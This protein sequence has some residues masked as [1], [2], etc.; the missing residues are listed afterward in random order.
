M[1]KKVKSSIVL[2]LCLSTN[3]IFGMLCPSTD[4]L[5]TSECFSLALQQNHCAVLSSF[6]C[7]TT[8]KFNYQ[9]ITTLYSY[10]FNSR[11]VWFCENAKTPFIL[12]IQNCDR[13]YKVTELLVNDGSIVHALDTQLHDHDIKII[14]ATANADI[15]SQDNSLVATVKYLTVPAL[16]LFVLYYYHKDPMMLIFFEKKFT[17]C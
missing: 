11:M 15:L 4:E 6:S 8:K 9:E 10:E 7:D 13:D 16:A 5:P 14:D 17:Q 1:K 12:K 3:L 2:L